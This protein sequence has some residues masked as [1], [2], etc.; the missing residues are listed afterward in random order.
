MAY[1]ERPE[2]QS[3]RIIWKSWAM[4]LTVVQQTVN[5]LSILKALL[6]LEAVQKLEIG[7]H[8]NLPSHS[9]IV[10]LMVSCFP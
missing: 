8:A 4:A 6:I 10:H 2:R 7:F 1:L 3:S 9:F 5:C